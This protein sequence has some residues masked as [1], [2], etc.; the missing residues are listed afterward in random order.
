MSA[1]TPSERDL[2][3]LINPD[4]IR[5]SIKRLF[6]GN[7]AEILG[8]LFQNS[9]RATAKNVHITTRPGGFTYEDDGHG[10]LGG[11]EGFHTMLSFGDSAFEN[12]TVADQEPMGLGLGSLLSHSLVRSVTFSS[13]GLS[14]R[15]ETEPWWNNAPYYQSWAD[16]LEASPEP[17]AGI[18]IDVEC[19]DNLVAQL[20]HS[21]GHT[22]PT[23][24]QYYV[25]SNHPAEGYDDLLA[26]TLDDRPVVSAVAPHRRLDKAQIVTTYEGCALRIQLGVSNQSLINWYGQLIDAGFKHRAAFYLHVR[27]GRPVNPKS[28]TR[29]G[30][31]NDASLHALLQFVKDAIFDF[32]FDPANRDEID[33]EWVETYY[34]LDP[35]RANREAPYF[36]ARALGSICRADSHSDL[37][38]IEKSRVLTYDEDPTLVEGSPRLLLPETGDALTE[39][40][41]ENLPYPD[42]DVYCSAGFASLL[43]ATGP[44]YELSKGNT[45]RLK[46]HTLWWRPGAE[47]CNFTDDLRGSPYCEWDEVGVMRL[48]EP[49]HWGL[50]LG[51]EPPS[52]W[53]AIEGRHVF[54]LSGSTNWSPLNV[55]WAVGTTSAAD[56]L[57]EF[58]WA[59]FTPEN[60]EHDGDTVES[61]YRQALAEIQRSLRGRC[62]PRNAVLSEIVD[63]ARRAM[64]D[65]RRRITELGLT[66][67]NAEEPEGADGQA[68]RYESPSAV[69]ATN[70]AGD[71]VTL[72]ITE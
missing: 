69:V 60:D 18:R 43:Q 16:R 53:H 24:P 32:L 66:Y 23:S 25:L 21:C 49:G 10:I 67:P 64:G 36:V 31:I 7:V 1:A 72:M 19:D 22:A 70:S 54:L 63:T 8:E 4:R 41:E 68:R 48:F 17:A 15:I 51:D 26:I 30:L 35:A 39:T 44:L 65:N 45:A 59:A 12:P 55:H 34:E 3:L 28:P 50:G 27:S 58:G 38:P 2:T 20:R 9:Q 52:E 14:L 47:T 11:V 37:D 13:G 6:G 71:T 57:R 46:I 62:V 56:F 40:D 33:P 61:A 29:S 42:T 5:S